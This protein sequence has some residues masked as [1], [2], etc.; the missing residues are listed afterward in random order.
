MISQQD[1]RLLKIYWLMQ[2]HS[3]ILTLN[4]TRKKK[5]VYEFSDVG[6]LI[7]YDILSNF[8]SAGRLSK[9]DLGL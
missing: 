8:S 4:E 3:Q 5:A 2:K 9:A 1:W 6:V 7:S